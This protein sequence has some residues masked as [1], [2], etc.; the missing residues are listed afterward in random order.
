[1]IRKDPN[2]DK[3]VNE[4]YEESNLSNPGDSGSLIVDERDYAV[5]LL[6]GG[7]TIDGAHFSYGIDIQDL[8]DILQLEPYKS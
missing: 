4:S 7:G 5:G 6:V 3:T 8:L 1:M 2:E